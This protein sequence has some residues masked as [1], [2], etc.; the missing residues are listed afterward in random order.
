MFPNETGFG[1]LVQYESI[2]RDNTWK[3]TEKIAWKPR[4]L[5]QIAVLSSATRSKSCEG[6]FVMGDRDYSTVL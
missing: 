3:K 5:L 1:T 2:E 4:L 6:F